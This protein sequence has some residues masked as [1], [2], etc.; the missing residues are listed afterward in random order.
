MSGGLD[1]PTVAAS[2]QRTLAR[3]GPATELCAYTMFANGLIPDEEH[4]YAGLVAEALEI[5]IEFQEEGMGLGNPRNHEDNRWPNP[6]I[7][8]GRMGGWRKCA[9]LRPGAEWR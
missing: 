5:P 8:P 4:H 9:R 7:C 6:C 1:S 2:A 3:R